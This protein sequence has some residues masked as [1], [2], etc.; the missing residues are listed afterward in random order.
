LNNKDIK[1]GNVYYA[2]LAHYYGSEQGGYRPVLIIQND[3]GNKYSQTTLVAPLTSKIAK[4]KLPTHVHLEAGNYGLKKDSIA[5]LEQ[6]RVIDKN[7]LGDFVTSIDY[8]KMIEVNNA[9]AV[10]FDIAS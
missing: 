5:L 9:I 3:V 2:N 4:K 10:S 6:V 1:K 7:L 8:E